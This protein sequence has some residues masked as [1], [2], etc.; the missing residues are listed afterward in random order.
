MVIVCGVLTGLNKG[1]FRVCSGLTSVIIPDGVTR[2]G[3]DAFMACSGL[4]SVTIG[5]SVTS[6]GR[7]AFWY[8]SGLT[9][10]NYNG[11]KAQW[12]AISKESYW[13]NYTGNYT[14]H[15]TDGDIAK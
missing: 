7:S 6:I 11:T 10:I 12:S 9:S 15:C 8:C 14:I 2:I 13:N 5:N 3:D 4:T 1:A